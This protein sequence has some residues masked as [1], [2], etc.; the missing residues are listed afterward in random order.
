MPGVTSKRCPNASY[1]NL[2]SIILYGRRWHPSCDGGNAH[3]PGTAGRAHSPGPERGEPAGRRLPA[4]SRP[5]RGRRAPRRRGPG[6]GPVA[7]RQPLRGGLH[8]RELR[9]EGPVARRRR[10]LRGRGLL[11]ERYQLFPRRWRGVEPRTN[12]RGAGELPTAPRRGDR[13]GRSRPDAGDRQTRHAVGDR[14]LDGFLDSVLEP[15]HVDGLPAPVVPLVHPSYQEVRNLRLGYE[16][17]TYVAALA[18]VLAEL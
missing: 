4:R 2:G 7:G 12:G 16:Y 17:E 5:R 15:V 6:P 1:R 3:A 8:R 14:S 18:R 9:A 13:T 11:H 10:G